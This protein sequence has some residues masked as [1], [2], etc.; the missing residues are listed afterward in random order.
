MYTNL[1]IISS[2][3]VFQSED[4]F[5]NP[6]KYPSNTITK[7]RT[8]ID[9]ELELFTKDGGITHINGNSFPIKKGDLL[10]AQ[11]GDKRQST[12]HFTAIYVHFGTH[13]KAIQELIRSICGFHMN[14]G[15]DK[16]QS[17]LSDICRTALSFEP[18]SD[19]SAAAKLISFLC[20]I[21]KNCLK[22]PS[23]DI[24]TTNHSVVSTAIEYMKQYYMEPITVQKIADYCCLSSSYFYKIFLATAHTTPN[25]YL[26]KIRLSAA[27]S[28]LVTT[29]LPISEIATSCGFNS[30]AYFSDCFKRQYAITPKDFRNSFLYPDAN[31]INS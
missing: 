28:L 26:I 8:V 30:Q 3:G 19:I 13:D 20:S 16:L 14:V 4:K 12:L 23:T 25:Q 21:K 27:K 2:A 31:T 29:A 1:P 24:A 5:S 17:E 18:D 10:I 7:L 22:N 6:E 15:Y 9:Y 11:P